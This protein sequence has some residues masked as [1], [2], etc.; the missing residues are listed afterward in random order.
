MRAG[1]ERFPREIATQAF[2]HLFIDGAGVSFLLSH[3]HVRQRFEDLLRLYLKLPRQ[4]VN[5]NFSHKK[6]NN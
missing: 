4:L 2:C 6:T 3:P 1:I 5:P